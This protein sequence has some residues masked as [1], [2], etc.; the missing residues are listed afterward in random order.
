M[1]LTLTV[2]LPASGQRTSVVVEAS[3]ATTVGEVAGGLAALAP[4]GRGHGPP[5]QAAVFVDG[6]PVDPRLPLA[7]SPIREGCVVSIGDASGCPPPESAGIVEIRMAGGP[8]AGTVHRLS[9]GH[10]TIG[11]APPAAIAV[12]D[13]TLPDDPLGIDIDSRGQVRLTVPG[14]VMAHGRLAA[15]RPAGRRLQSARPR[16]L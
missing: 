5:G 9:L 10:A 7:G 4:N 6:R 14:G 2:A 12:A 11:R 15:R 16:G 8:A 1:R 3:R 13:P